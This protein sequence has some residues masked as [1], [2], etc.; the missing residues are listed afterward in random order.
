MFANLWQ[1]YRAAIVIAVST[2]IALL[3]SVVVVPETEQA[4]V[5]RF[6]EPVRVIN[7]FRTDA[8]FGQTGA[9]LSL[10]IPFA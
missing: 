4:V 10:R 5:L 7:R 1:A 2:V 9:G 6:G 3:A 8:D